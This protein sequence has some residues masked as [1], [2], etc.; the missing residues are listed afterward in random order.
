MHPRKENITVNK[1]K[2][3]FSYDVESNTLTRLVRM[4]KMKPGPT[5]G[6]SHCCGYRAIGIN[7]QKYLVHRVIWALEYGE[8]P[9]ELIDHRDTDK[10][11]NHVDNMRPANAQQNH[12]NTPLQANNTSGVKGVY[13]HKPVGKWKAQITVAGRQITKGYFDSK[14]DAIEARREM[15]MKYQGVYRFDGGYGGS[16]R[17]HNHRGLHV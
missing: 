8:W 14:D 12:A 1:L 7:G 2:K 4:G 6:T 5:T 17:I 9:P 3:L 10:V 11:H 16:T 15:E 13:W